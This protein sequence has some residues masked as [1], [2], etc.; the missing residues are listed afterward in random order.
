MLK[1]IQCDSFLSQGKKRPPI[2]FDRGL[3][4][5]LGEVSTENSIGK[6]TMLSIIDFCFGG[7]AFPKQDVKSYIG[8]D[9]PINFTF[10]F[11]G[12]EYSYARY[13]STPD[14]V[15]RCSRQYERQEKISLEEF[16]EELKE[17]YGLTS[18]DLKFREYVG[19]LIRYYGRGEI[20]PEFP[21]DTN[22]A[23]ATIKLDWLEKIFGRYG[24]IKE[25]KEEIDQI[26]DKKKALA[27]AR[28]HDFLP[29]KINKKEYEKNEEKISELKYSLGNIVNKA[30]KKITQ[31]DLEQ[32][33]ET[34]SITSGINELKSK[35]RN[36]IAKEK[37]LERNI[38]NKKEP[39]NED[40]EKL[41][42]FFP[43]VDFER[44]EF[45][46]NFHRKITGIL[47]SEME[48][49]ANSIENSLKAINTEIKIKEDELRKKGNHVN[50]NADVFEEY[51]Q[52]KN[53]I[54]IL[55]SSNDRY[56]EDKEL[57]DRR[58]RASS[59]LTK[60]EKIV[61]NSIFQSLNEKIA[62][63]EEYI[64]SDDRKPPTIKMTS[65]SGY[66]YR[67]EQNKGTK[68]AYKSL[69]IFDLALLNLTEI[70]FMI[71]DSFIFNN[72]GDSQ[73][74]KIL[75]LYL[76][77][78]KKQIF[79]AFD[80]ANSYKG[81]TKT[82]IDQ[83]CVLQLSDNGNELYGESWAKKRKEIQNENKAE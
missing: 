9:N 83:H 11:N 64:F 7:D 71:H 14:L 59:E 26:N 40:I 73:L 20:K 65:K 28:K 27:E 78:K 4:T 24:E 29:K 12:K 75:E 8:K 10:E 72:I 81:N 61:L 45:V 16:N 34:E 62:S 23:K 76:K 54:F 39:T 50:I 6:T 43:G 55:K 68:A 42:S 52:Q 53:E 48:E 3:N 79:I 18:S 38:E 57:T 25:Y 49:E 17:K 30:D 51:S 36:L 1:E 2:I 35:Q 44:L 15:W 74:E 80:K 41:K 32:A 82:I 60:K 37:L 69:V 66:E 63:Y 77:E 13:E 58:K 21:L 31:E 56:L 67:A 47:S 70:P 22:N 46:L 33:Y 5:I 19:V